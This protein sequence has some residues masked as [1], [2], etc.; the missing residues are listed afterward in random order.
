MAPLN[1]PETIQTL[2][3]REED[4][5]KQWLLIAEDRDKQADARHNRRHVR[6][7]V[8]AAMNPAAT[9]GVLPTV[10]ALSTH[11]RRQYSVA[12]LLQSMLEPRRDEPLSLE[13][14]ISLSI[15]KDLKTVPQNGG[16]YVPLRI[17]AAGLDTKTNAAGAYLT[18]KRLGDIIDALRAHTRV[19][20]LG[21]QVLTGLKY[22][23]LFPVELTSTTATWVAENGGSDVS[24]S[25][26]TF[27][28]RTLTPKTLQSTTSISRQLLAQA[29]QDLELWT[30][31]RIGKA[32]AL[33]LDA[34]AI[35]GSGSANQPLGLLKTSGLGDVALGASGLAPTADGIR[36]LEASVASAN[37]DSDY[38]AFLTTSVMRQKLRAVP[39]LT[40]GS[41][42]IWEDS[43]MLG[44]PA[45]ASN[46]VPATLTKG[47]NNDCNAII[48]GDWSMLLVGEFLGALEIVLDP[49]RLKK[50]GMVEISSFGMYDIMLTQP[51]ALAAIQ[52]ARNV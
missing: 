51:S 47:A 14:E 38:C 27:G 5:Q 42:P 12:A 40:G 16:V 30:R 50:Q 6:A 46:Q 29:N 13:R 41:N 11:E 32:H 28:Q 49:Y 45:F 37:A 31:N 17:R 35:N 8:E 36:A 3:R 25:D 22:A 39:E 19:L 4:L 26:S 33:A 52:D 48:F 7:Q 20:Q 23:Q 44:Y 24:D 43:E 34:A 1:S 15:A 9:A 10:A 21:A 2:L 18:E